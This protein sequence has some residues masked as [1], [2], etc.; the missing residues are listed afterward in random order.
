[1]PSGFQKWFAK[2]FRI[3]HFKSLK[4]RDILVF[5]YQQGWLYL[6]LIVITFIAGINYA[7]NLILGFCFLISSV[8]CISFYLTFKQ[9]HQLQIE[10]IYPEVGQLGHSLILKLHYKQTRASARF[11]Q[12]RV[13]DQV[14]TVLIDQISQYAELVF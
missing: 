6:T 9:L 5:I 10:M 7:N 3:D 14:H 8:L 4:Q 11:I 2:R 13:E 1:M 12:I